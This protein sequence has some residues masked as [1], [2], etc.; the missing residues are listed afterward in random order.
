MSKVVLDP[1]TYGVITNAEAIIDSCGNSVIAAYPRN[2]I[3][4]CGN[5]V[6]VSH[7]RCLLEDF[8][9]FRLGFRRTSV[10]TILTPYSIRTI[11]GG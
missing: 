1:I 8:C 7:L 4:F 11:F 3:V 2:S 10:I 6:R 9:P 5:R